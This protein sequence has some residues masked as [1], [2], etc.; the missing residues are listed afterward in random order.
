MTRRSMLYMYSFQFQ[1]LFLC[2]PCGPLSIEYRV[3][4]G[5]CARHLTSS[6]VS[7]RHHLVVILGSNVEQSTLKVACAYSLVQTCPLTVA[8]PCTSSHATTNKPSGKSLSKTFPIIA[9]LSLSWQKS[10]QLKFA[11]EYV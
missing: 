2:T 8:T 3:H 4:Q 9:D 10:T 7:S 6:H 5:V 11:V 1:C